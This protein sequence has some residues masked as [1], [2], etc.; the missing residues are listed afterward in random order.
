V[1]CAFQ[2]ILLCVAATL[3]FA[4]FA[5]TNAIVSPCS[6]LQQGYPSVTASILAGNDLFRSC[7]AAGF[8]CVSLFS[9]SH[10]SELTTVLHSASSAAPS[11]RTS[12][13][14]PPRLSSPACE[15][16][17]PRRPFISADE[18]LCRRNILFIIP[19]WGLYLYGDRLRK[20]SKFG[21][22]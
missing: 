14:G 7:M 18:T 17:P 9:I 22:S 5:T 11:L 1:F 19:L 4:S 20:R 10:L 12:A 6:Y 15:C 21:Q 2:C 8:P 13:S 3:V 16:D